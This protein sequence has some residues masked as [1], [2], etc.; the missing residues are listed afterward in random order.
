MPDPTTTSIDV[1]DIL[2]VDAQVLATTGAPIF[3]VTAT[4]FLPK[5]FAR[6][7]AE[8]LALARALIG[9]DLDLSSGSVFRKLLELSALED[10]RTWAALGAAFD[11]MYVVSATGQALS[12][13]GSELG[14]S[15]PYLEAR[16]QV[17]L[18]LSGPLPSGYSQLTIPRGARLATPGGHAVATDETVVLS[19]ANPQR[20]V[21]AVAFYPGPSHNLDPT[22]P[23]T[24]NSFPQKIDRWDRVDALL[25]DLVAAEEAASQTLVTIEHTDR[26]S[27]GQLQ[28]PDDRYRTLLLQA[29]RSMWTVDAVRIALS[30]VPGVRQALV[31]DGWG[32]LDL[33]Q[34]IFG[35]FN[36]IERL[37]SSERDL[38]TP[39][40]FTVLVAPT[41]AAI[42]D[43][44]DGLF[45]AVQSAIEDLRPAGIFPQ[46]Q[47]AV[48][49]G[50]GIKAN[51]V[52]RGLPLPSGST[53]TVNASDAAVNL[54]QRLLL[55]LRQ[56]VDALQLGEPVRA[57][58]VTWA[59][60]NEPGI[61]DVQNLTLLRF[62]P[63]VDNLD[64]GTPVGAQ[65]E[66]IGNGAN[67]DLQINQIAVA[68]EDPSGLTIV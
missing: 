5:P 54:K 55:R 7:L 43:G 9:E 64:F 11:N 65:P 57:A 8:K 19:P 26:F 27:G 35:N 63:G 15:R 23:G 1:A 61:T 24:D 13:L 2:A 60:M 25:A 12:D 66:P 38:G 40:Y 47:Q 58:E 32:G 52:V 31:R 46:I 4:G 6:L 14:L 28:W 53:A 42:W 17:K 67:V 41:A 20:Q 29:P 34:S 44:P 37:F 18:S 62:P 16:G 50:V 22:V 45:V 33:Q 49:V 48:Q 59:L 10:A 56:Y 36:F 51:L 39:Y 30:L 68:V 3:G 21:A